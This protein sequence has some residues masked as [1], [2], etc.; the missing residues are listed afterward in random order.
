MVFSTED[1]VLIKVLRQEK[2]L[3]QLMYNH[4]ASLEITVTVHESVVR[5]VTETCVLDE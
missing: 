1:L 5:V 4:T 3:R 2:R